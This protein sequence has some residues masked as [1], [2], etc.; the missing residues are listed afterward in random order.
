MT[1]GIYKSNTISNNN[2]TTR[3]NVKVNNNMG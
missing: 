3:D 1:K 2:I